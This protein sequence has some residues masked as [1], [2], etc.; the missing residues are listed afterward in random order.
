MPID[1]I[2][3]WGLVA[4]AWAPITVDGNGNDVYGT[5][6]KFK[7]LR[8][9]TFTANGEMVRVYADGTTVYIG[10][11]NNGYS[12]SMEFTHPDEE[13]LKYAL[14]ET[15]D[16]NGLQYEP[17]EPPV[18]RFAFLW[19]WQGDQKKTR[20]CMYNCTA[21]R[22]DLSVITKG[23][24][25][26]KTAQYQTLN[27]ESAARANDDVVK[28]RTR[29]DTDS[30]V[31]NNWFNTVPTIAAEGTQKVTVTVTDGTD[32]VSGALVILGDGT[33]GVTDTAGQIVFYKL[34]GTYDLFV[35]ASGFE[36]AASSVT[37]STSA[38]TKTVALTEIV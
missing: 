14:G 1:N 33:L 38:V 32:P 13:F 9:V 3:N 6:H 27:V 22:P 5:V 26:N 25:G 11:A 10:K 7:G 37:V 21:S 31:Y 19:E 17:L 12:G 2:V 8:S 30:T 34:A 24:G 4:S 23:D 29:S 35:S 18:N 36:G 15:V 20:H 28:V 16:S